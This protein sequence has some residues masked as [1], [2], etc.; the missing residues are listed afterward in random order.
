MDMDI[1][2]SKIKQGSIMKRRNKQ[3]AGKEAKRK[4][5]EII[6]EDNK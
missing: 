1:I 5:K 6:E 2:E 4:D 3:S